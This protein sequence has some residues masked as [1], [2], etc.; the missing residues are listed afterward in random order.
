MTL[1]CLGD[2][3][4][5][6]PGVRP[7]QKWTALAA[8]DGLH[9][10]NLGVPGDT[11]VGMLAR[12]QRL[13]LSSGDSVLVMGGTN[14]IFC[15]LTDAGARAAMAAVVQQ[16]LAKG[17]R[18][19]VGIPIPVVPDIAPEKWKQ[20]V[21]FSAASAVLDQ[22]CA[23]L[24]TYCSTFDIPAV[25][26]REDYVNQNGAVRRELYLD[27]LHPNTAG[28]QVMAQRLLETLR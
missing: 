22:Y 16:L 26:F 15:T 17:L 19:V 6:G 2:S 21:D 27:G 8:A 10:V 4:T 11:A 13:E 28:H 20:L 25:D 14:D 3:L 18:P 1:Y 5:F 23:W 12:L 7:S 24:K 9:I